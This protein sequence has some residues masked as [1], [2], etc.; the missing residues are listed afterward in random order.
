[1]EIT[2]EVPEQ[3]QRVKLEREADKKQ[4]GDDLKSGA[5]FSFARLVTKQSLQ[6]K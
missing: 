4:I 6:I 3:Y 5:E 2:G 1:V